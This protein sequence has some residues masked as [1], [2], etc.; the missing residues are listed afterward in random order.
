MKT[1]HC[2][3]CDGEMQVASDATALACGGCL[4]KVLQ[5]SAEEKAGQ[6]AKLRAQGRERAA[7][8]IEKFSGLGRY[9][10]RRPPKKPS[11]VLLVEFRKAR[12]LTQEEL[13]TEWGSHGSTSTGW[14]TANDPFQSA[15]C[16]K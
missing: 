13:A 7:E 12:D 3:I 10:K 16:R 4:Q 5:F 2:P 8:A 11:N 1:D 9:A 6:I 14:R 15:S